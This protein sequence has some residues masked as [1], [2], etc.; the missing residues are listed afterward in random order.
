[1]LALIDNAIQNPKYRVPFSKADI[2]KAVGEEKYQMYIDN[3][4]GKVLENPFQNHLGIETKDELSALLGQERYKQFVISLVN[5]VVQSTNSE[6]E[7]NYVLKQQNLYYPREAI[8][9]MVDKK[10]WFLFLKREAESFSGNIGR[11]I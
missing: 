9:A 1:M 6:R 3:L 8:K 2:V 5:K 4:L 11:S 10:T 7:L